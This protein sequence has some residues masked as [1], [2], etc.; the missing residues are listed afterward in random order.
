[1]TAVVRKLDFIKASLTV[2]IL[3]TGIEG[4]ARTITAAIEELKARLRCLW[5]QQP[6]KLGF[7]AFK[8]ISIGF[9]K[10]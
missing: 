4:Y 7:E 8:L 3:Q 10:L 9:Q 6:I 1:M 5:V 2:Y